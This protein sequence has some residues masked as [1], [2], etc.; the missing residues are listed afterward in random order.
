MRQSGA[1]RRLGQHF[2]ADASAVR[3]IV[4]AAHIEPG[5]LVVEIGPGRGALTGALLERASQVVGIE[6]DKSLC[7]HLTRTL[8]AQHKFSILNSDVLLVDLAALVRARGFERAVLVGNLPYSITGAAVQQILDVRAV[9]SRAV[10][11][12]QRE[13]AQRIAAPPGGKAYGILSVAVQIRT[14]PERLFDLSPMCFE[15]P[16]RVHSSVVRLDFSCASPVMIQD[17]RLF[18][19][20]VRRVFGQ[21]RKMIK[22]TILG[23]PGY[24]KEQLIEAFSRAEIDLHLRPESI[25]ATEYE[26]ICRALCALSQ[27]KSSCPAV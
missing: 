23:L 5:D 25:S 24:N 14:L 18:F 22:N 20:V 13:V 16:P 9:F 10:L 17:E 21:R 3:Q 2:L 4:E 12:V 11:M 26:R 1:R 8:G 7:E 19:Q 6:L 15:P 27:Q